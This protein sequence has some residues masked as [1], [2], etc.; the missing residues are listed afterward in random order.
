[1]DSNAYILEFEGEARAK[2]VEQGVVTLEQVM[3]AQADY[4]S[5][6]QKLEEEWTP[7]K[8][9]VHLLES[10]RNSYAFYVRRLAE[11]EAENRDARQKGVSFS[12][13][14]GLYSPKIEALQSLMK[15]TREHGEKLKRS[16]LQP[17]RAYIKPFDMDWVQEK[18]F[19]HV[20][21]MKTL[22]M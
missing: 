3:D 9:R 4:D 22:G 19:L 14:N 21:D 1:M 5:F 6:I 11:I 15:E 13:R 18:G 2:L 8:I 7:E 12:V 10:K 16:P 20:L 17:A